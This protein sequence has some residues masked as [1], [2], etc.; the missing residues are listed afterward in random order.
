MQQ[1][2]KKHTAGTRHTSM[3]KV[4]LL[5]FIYI[6]M[7]S[8]MA[9]ASSVSTSS[10]AASR[11]TA[12]DPGTDAGEEIPA[13][14]YRNGMVSAGLYHTVLLREDGRVYCWGDNSYGQLGIGSTE[15]EEMPTLVPDLVNI[16]MVSAG[17]YHTIALSEDGTVYAWGRN[18]FGQIGNGTSAVALSPVRIDSI[19]PMKEISAGAF[20]TLALSID[21]KVYAWGDNNEFQVGDVQAENVVDDT[22]NILGKRV[23][24]PQLVVE[25]GVKAISA[26]GNHSL[27]LSS[28]GHVYAWGSNKYGQLGDGSQVSRGLPSPVYGLSSIIKISAGYSHNLA[29]K[30]VISTG[31]ETKETYQN[32]YVWGSDSDGQLGLGEAF[33]ETRFVDRPT[34]VDITN[35]SNEKNDQI[36]LIKAGYSNSMITVPV[37]KKG[38]RYDSIYIWG[39]NTYGQ[40]GIGDLTSQ[41]IPVPLIATSNGWTGSVFLPF[42]S[43]A[44]GGYHTVFLSVKGFVG[45]A[46]RANKGQLGNVSSIDS[47]IPVGVMVPDAIEPEWTSFDRL[48][49]AKQ[50]DTILLTWPEAKD[51]IKVTGYE[52]SYIAN[53]NETKNIELGLVKQYTVMNYNQAAEQL[54]TV[55]AVDASGN[56]SVIPLEYKYKAAAN[57]TVSGVDSE[58]GSEEIP[59]GKDILSGTDIN[60]SEGTPA[61]SSSAA[62]TSSVSIDTAA[63]DVSGSGTTSEDTTVIPETANPLVWNPML[64]G[65]ITPLEVPWNVDYIYGEGVVLPPKDYSGL[66]VIFSA[67]AITT[68][69]LFLGAVSFRK[70]HKGQRLFQGVFKDLSNNRNARKNP[71]P[72]V[73]DDSIVHIGDGIVLVQEDDADVSTDIPG[74]PEKKSGR[75]EKNPKNTADKKDHPDKQDKQKGKSAD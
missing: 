28:D 5:L 47:K 63:S 51:N 21:G 4:F 15:N 31:S 67:I 55:R 49:A 75:K 7:S 41:N 50:Y 68:F 74:V 1:P 3:I 71:E 2:N 24:K 18:S 27:Y 72:T 29:L 26:G 40:L 43:V 33:N 64:Y 9:F 17:A 20:H 65:T 60:S 8:N 32:L 14:S 57:Q 10:G 56:K 48:Q 19:P 58:A 42:Q 25:S 44:I 54:I 70:K 59:S 6:F 35:D 73:E 66:I 52:V 53:N 16:V 36:S 61:Q 22:G 30:E 39:N 62:V 37:I 34:R 12:S 45:V 23:A 11:N 13:T 38:K 46:G 69:F